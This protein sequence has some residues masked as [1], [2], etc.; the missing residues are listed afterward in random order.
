[1]VGAHDS[2]LPLSQV[3]AEPSSGAC[4]TTGATRTAGA[5]RC[6]LPASGRWRACYWVAWLN[7]SVASVTCGLISIQPFMLADGQ[8]SL[9]LKPF[10]E[11]LIQGVGRVLIK[12]DHARAGDVRIQHD[13]TVDLRQAQVAEAPAAVYLT[14]D[15]DGALVV[16]ATRNGPLVFCLRYVNHD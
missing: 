7:A 12:R 14:G 1:M 11:S 10:P 3:D 5:R 6:R 4:S 9:K 13:V 2:P 16:A 15:G 8:C